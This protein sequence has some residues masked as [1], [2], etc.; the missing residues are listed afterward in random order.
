[1]R[2]S[3]SRSS[4]ENSAAP[5]PSYVSSNKPALGHRGSGFHQVIEGFLRCLHRRVLLGE[6]EECR[7][8]IH[9]RADAD[10]AGI[11]QTGSLSMLRRKPSV[12]QF[13]RIS[14][15]QGCPMRAGKQKSHG[16]R[17]DV[18]H[19]ALKARS[20]QTAARGRVRGDPPGKP[21]A[22]RVSC[23]AKGSGNIDPVR[24]CISTF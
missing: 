14:G 6:A 19:G 18:W 17:S 10:R 13:L 15:M 8:N 1:M 5:G 23:G 21:P 24:K 22:R 2:V 12:S 16:K 11:L 9:Q 4:R 20:K 3:I 7:G